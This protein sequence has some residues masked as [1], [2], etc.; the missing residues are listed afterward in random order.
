MLEEKYIS[1]KLFFHNTFIFRTK[2]SANSSSNGE[3]KGNN[4]EIIIGPYRVF[5]GR[6]SVIQTRIKLL[7]YRFLGNQNFRRC[8]GKRPK[9]WWKPQCCYFDSGYKILQNYKRSRFHSFRK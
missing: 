5:P 4:P 9:I 8:R 1:K 3:S 2:A 6:L 7:Y